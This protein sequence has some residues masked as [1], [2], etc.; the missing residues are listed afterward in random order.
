MFDGYDEDA[1]TE[2]RSIWKEVRARGLDATY[3][4]QNDEGRWEKKA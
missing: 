3:W 2:A 1:L 4:Q